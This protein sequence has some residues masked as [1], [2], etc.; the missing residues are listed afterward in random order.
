MQKPVCLFG[1]TG[2]FMG[3]TVKI[4]TKPYTHFTGIGYIY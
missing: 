2:F 3:Y 1:K 4:F